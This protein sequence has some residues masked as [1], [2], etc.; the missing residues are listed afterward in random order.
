MGEEE[1][2]QLVSDYCKQKYGKSFDEMV[3][4]MFVLWMKGEISDE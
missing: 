4:E 1:L 2:L 3:E